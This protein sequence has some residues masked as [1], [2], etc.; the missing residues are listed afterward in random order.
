MLMSETEEVALAAA[1]DAALHRCIADREQTSAVLRDLRHQC[2]GMVHDKQRRSAEI[3]GPDHGARGLKVTKVV[4]YWLDDMYEDFSEWTNPT[5]LSLMFPTWNDTFYSSKMQ[6]VEHENYV[7]MDAN[8]GPIVVTMPNVPTEDDGNSFSHIFWS[9]KG[10]QQFKVARDVY[11]LFPQ[12]SARVRI[13]K[14]IVE[15]EFGV[16][17]ATRL[18]RVTQN[19][20]NEELD[21]YEKSLFCANY[22]FGVLYAKE[23]QSQNEMFGNQDGSP[24]FHHFLELLGDRIELMGWSNF[25][26]GLDVKH[27]HTGSHSVYSKVQ[28]GGGVNG[29]S[30][31]FEVMFHVS[32]ML[33]YSEKDA[34]QLERKRHLGNDIVIILFLEPK[35]D[36][37][38]E[39]V[40][41]D[42]SI[43]KSEFNHAFIVVQPL[44]MGVDG[45]R[46]YN[47]ACIFK[48]GVEPCN[49]YI[50]SP[51]VFEHGP[52]FRAWLLAKLINSERTSYNCKTFSHKLNRT[53]KVQL[54]LLVNSALDVE[55]K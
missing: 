46:R 37:S 21:A 44:R 49:P 19:T 31:D 7:A 41:Y 40:V 52:E 3:T 30:F 26:G 39:P 45:K 50:P 18:V 23:G 33:P 1:V 48:S 11:E 34:Q 25:R 29:R 8:L 28:M 6:L 16:A 5:N 35:S 36:D 24:A 15:N 13:M 55:G 27:G 43:I 53:R 42:P 14:R 9:D 17:S 51:G 10:L 22:K 12:Q 20:V 38:D 47:V 32:T 54:Q 4:G 2:D